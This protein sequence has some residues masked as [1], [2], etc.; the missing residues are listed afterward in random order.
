MNM[1]KAFQLAH[2]RTRTQKINAILLRREFK[3]KVTFAIELRKAIAEQPKKLTT[4]TQHG[5]IVTFIKPA[6]KRINKACAMVGDYNPNK[7][8]HNDILDNMVYVGAMTYI[9][10]S[11]VILLYTGLTYNL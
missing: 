10:M 3:Y 2:R 4:L 11:M 5:R 1:S 9:I 8:A 7:P 6:K